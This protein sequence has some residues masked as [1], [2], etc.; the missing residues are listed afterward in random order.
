M[1]RRWASLDQPADLLVDRSAIVPE[2]CGP[3]AKNS[4]R[5]PSLPYASGPI[6]SLMP[7]STTMARAMSVARLRSSAA[8]VEICLN[9]ISSAVRPP[10]RMASRSASSGSVSR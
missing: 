6:V 9:A 5:G 3:C 2:Y 4:R 8:P 1:A 7:Y 10:S